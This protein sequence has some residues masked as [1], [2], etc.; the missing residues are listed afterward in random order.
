MLLVSIP[1]FG[2]TQLW[3]LHACVRHEVSLILSH[4]PY[5]PAILSI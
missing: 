5:F 3:R 1:S 4:L 2:V